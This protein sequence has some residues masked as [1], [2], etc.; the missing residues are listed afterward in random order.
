MKR[1]TLLLG[2][3]GCQPVVVGSLPP[4]SERSTTNDFYKYSVGF[5]AGCRKGQAGSLCSP[6]TSMCCAVRPTLLKFFVAIV[7]SCFSQIA[8]A[9][10]LEDVL[11]TTLEKNPIIQEAK[12]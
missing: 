3:T 10:T 5:S 2:S 12:S 4:I 7:M 1:G 8:S 11:Q 9:I 6:E